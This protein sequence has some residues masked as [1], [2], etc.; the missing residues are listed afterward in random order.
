MPPLQTQA[1]RPVILAVGEVMLRLAPPGRGPLNRVG[2]FDAT[3]GGSEANAGVA[4]ASWGVPTR[5]LTALPLNALGDACLHDLR[6]WG[7]DTSS[8]VR[9]EGRMGLYFVEHG[10]GPRPSTV[11]YDRAGSAFATLSPDSVDLDAALEGVGW[12]HWSGITPAL[13]DGP[14]ALLERLLRTGRDRGAVISCDL[15]YRARLWSRESARAAMTR[16]VSL[17]DICIGNEE[18]AEAALG[19]DTAGLHPGLPDATARYASLGAEMRS[20]FGFRAVAFSLRRS[21]SASRNIWGA[22]LVSDETGDRGALAGE[23]EID[24]I[25]DRFGAGDAFAAGIIHGLR[26]GWSPGETVR[27]AAAA[28]A[29][30][31]T[32]P[33]DF[34]TSSIAD[35]RA[36]AAG[37]ATGRVRR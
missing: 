12:V 36:L 9:A 13:G 1:D 6:G 14:R 21:L 28:G 26:Q 23:A 8:V 16:L 34:L 17:V 20:R 15:N 37:D 19:M 35:I 22:M 24:G 31:H 18:D 27:F 5:L 30:K 33:G 2:A 4:L 11:L 10:A 25:V 32:V 3:W 7:V 29:L